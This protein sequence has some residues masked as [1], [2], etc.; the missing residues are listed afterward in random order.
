[1]I[2]ANII[3]VS[4]LAAAAAATVAA[5]AQAVAV[6]MKQIRGLLYSR[7]LSDFAELV[8]Q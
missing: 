6:I 5:A 3:H 8:C 7:G 1:L 2:F 4:L